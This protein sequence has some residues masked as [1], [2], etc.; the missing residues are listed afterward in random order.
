MPPLTS[1][2]MRI[3]LLLSCALL[4]AGSRPA[5]VAEPASRAAASPAA[6][7]IYTKKR[8]PRTP[9]LAQLPRRTSVSKDGISWTFSRSAPVGK[10]VTGDFYV[11][12]PVTVTAISPPPTNGRNG[13][14]KNL[15]PVDD[16]TGFDSRTD[17]NRYDEDVR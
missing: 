7:P 13:S 17:A 6:V 12:G 10:F 15:P 5:A 11:V 2:A 3:V 9:K 1:P 8:P 14:V 4:L 16:E